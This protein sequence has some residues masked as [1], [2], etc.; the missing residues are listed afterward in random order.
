MESFDKIDT[1]ATTNHIDILFLTETWHTRPCLRFIDS[2]HLHRRWTIL[3][4]SLL[5][6][7]VVKR[8]A[9]SVLSKVTF[10]NH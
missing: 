8:M 1:L 9:F 5:T 7:P 4:T 10:Y 3:G 2:L 6:Y